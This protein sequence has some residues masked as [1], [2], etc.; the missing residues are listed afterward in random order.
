[1][2]FSP[3]ID[4]NTFVCLIVSRSISVKIPSLNEWDF[5]KK[6]CNL[7]IQ[8][9]GFYISSRAHRP[10]LQLSFI[11]WD[12]AQR[13]HAVIYSV[14]QNRSFPLCVHEVLVIR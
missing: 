2:K 13:G 1:M 8:G 11:Y 10:F 4:S 14:S 5:L 6:V 9:F 3:L 12:I 7:E